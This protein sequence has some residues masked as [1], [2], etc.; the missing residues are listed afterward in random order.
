LVCGVTYLS[1]HVL[2]G[3]DSLKWGEFDAIQG[4]YIFLVAALAICAMVLPGISGSTIML[5]FGIYGA[6][7]EGIKG[8]IKGA[9]HLDFS[10]FMGLFIFG[11]GV[12]VGIC[13]IVR[14]LKVTLAKNRSAVTYFIV[15]MMVASLYAVVM[16][17][18]SPSLENPSA[19]LSLDT[20]SII[21]FV[22]GIGCIV[23]LQFLKMKLVKKN[24]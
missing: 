8:F 5:I 24:G 6:V 20:F 3:V 9:L 10:Y 2:P 21:W 16:G 15:G 17:P 19:P 22:I 18:A 23:G 1:T 4:V 12:I 14:V 11:M 7:M 13:T